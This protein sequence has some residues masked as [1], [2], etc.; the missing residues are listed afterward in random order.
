MR[1]ENNAVNSSSLYSDNLKNSSVSNTEKKLDPQPNNLQEDAFKA[2][3]KDSE[4]STSF[5]SKIKGL[6]TKAGAAILGMSCWTATPKISEERKQEIMSVVQPGDIILANNDN[7][8]SWEIFEHIVG[9]GDYTHS[10]IYEGDGNFI[11]ASASARTNGGVGRTKLSDYIKGRMNFQIIRPPYESKEDIAAALNYADSQ[12]GK[13]YDMAFKYDDNEI[14]CSELVA[15]ALKSMPNEIHTPTFQFAGREAVLPDDFRKLEGAQVV[16]DDKSTFL[17]S[18]LN[19]SP[20]LLGG[21]ALAVG[22]GLALGPVGAVIGL[23]AGTLTTSIVGGKIQ[24]A[25]IEENQKPPVN[26]NNDIISLNHGHS[27]ASPAVS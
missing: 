27:G 13:K 10:A 14:Y 1:L 3:S 19:L 22:A 24:V 7:Y 15:K 17:K 4:A 2:S 5:S 25:N 11:E 20:A 9:G 21:A 8:P 26:D 23:V 6:A 12:I 16:Y 18:M